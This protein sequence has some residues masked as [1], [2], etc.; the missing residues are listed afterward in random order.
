MSD[1]DTVTKQLSDAIEQD[2][3]FLPDCALQVSDIEQRLTQLKNEFRK[4][5]Q[6]ASDTN[7]MEE[8]ADQFRSISVEMSGLKEQRKSLQ[9]QL[10]ETEQAIGR[11]SGIIESLQDLSPRL[12]E[13]N[14]GTIRQLV[15]SVRVLSANKI[16]VSLTS[17]IQIEQEI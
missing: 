4:L 2:L 7:G 12:T 3:I 16:Q 13:W 14:E 11:T 1:K 15:T 9:V 6:L 5:M 17:G 10:K 8:Y